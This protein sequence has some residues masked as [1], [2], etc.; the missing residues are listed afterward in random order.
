VIASLQ[1]VV[2]HRHI[3]YTL[4]WVILNAISL[5]LTWLILERAQ[6]RTIEGVA[7]IECAMGSFIGIVQAYLLRH[8]LRKPV[9]WIV[10]SSLIGAIAAAGTVV[11]KVLI[12]VA[13][14]NFIGGVAI[15]RLIYSF[16]LGNALTW[17]AASEDQQE[18]VVR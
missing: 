6:L 5:I 15:G 14:L 9:R 17:H 18:N 8:Q 3:S 16:L 4:L 10:V 13:P 7:L 1:W 2:L 12:P 11:A